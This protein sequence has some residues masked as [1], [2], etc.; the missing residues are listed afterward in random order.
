MP[1][2]KA[3]PRA[4]PSPDSAVVARTLRESAAALGV[5]LDPD[6]A[7]RL[8]DF[9]RELLRWNARVDLVAPTD[10]ATFARRHLLDAL[11]LLPL[12][13]DLGVRRLIDLGSGAGLPGLVL[14]LVEPGLTVESLEPRS[15]RAAFQRHVTRLFGLGGVRVT[16]A[17]AERGGPPPVPPADAAV[18]RAVAPL[19]DL[20]A[21]A[22]PLARPGGVVLAMHGPAD[23]AESAAAAAAAAG[24]VLEREHAY[25]LPGDDRDGPRSRTVLV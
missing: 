16:E 4:A 13:R 5:R 19:P 6:A 21:L 10:L 20:V 15:R 14:A 8:V 11:A 7:G 1:N 18:A 2:R 25:T 9:G 12:L 17:R 23:S 24:L 3:P 22:A